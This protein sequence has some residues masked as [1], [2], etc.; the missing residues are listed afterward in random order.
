MTSVPFNTSE[1]K[2]ISSGGYGNLTS[3][4]IKLK[5]D[6]MFLEFISSLQIVNTICIIICATMKM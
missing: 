5:Q 2:S 1:E 6:K 4:V 3:P